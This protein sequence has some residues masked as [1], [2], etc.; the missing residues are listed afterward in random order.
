MDIHMPVMDGLTS[1]RQIRA[2]PGARG[3]VPIV[4]LT[5]DVIN[6]AAEKAMAAGMN[7]FLSKPLQKTHLL[8]VMPSKR[9]QAW[10]AQ[11]CC[12]RGRTQVLSALQPD[13]ADYNEILLWSF[14]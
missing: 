14:F 2:M 4:A 9:R 12:Q 5:A 1:A 8:A 10:L 6:D 7:A 11:R 13:S 3:Q